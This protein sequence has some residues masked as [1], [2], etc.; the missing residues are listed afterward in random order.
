MRLSVMAGLNAKLA[1]VTTSWQ[2]MRSL[3]L[4]ED[5]EEVARQLHTVTGKHVDLSQVEDLVAS[6][7]A[8]TLYRQALS[9]NVH[10][11]AV[12]P[13]NSLRHQ[14]STLPPLISKGGYIHTRWVWGY[15][16]STASSRLQA[17]VSISLEMGI[18]WN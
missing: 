17:H 1:E 6:G 9:S 14:P 3:W 8:E 7:G 12:S 5:R 4:E 15:Q 16:H 13:D 18:H 2:E 11:D 10:G